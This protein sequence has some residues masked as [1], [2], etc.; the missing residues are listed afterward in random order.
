MKF[1][2]HSWCQ[3]FIDAIF[4]ARDKFPRKF[5]QISNFLVVQAEKKFGK[6]SVKSMMNET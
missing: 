3:R 1:L 6:A 4:G 2:V 5:Y